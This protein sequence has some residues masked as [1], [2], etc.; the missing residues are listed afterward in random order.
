MVGLFT[1][2]NWLPFNAYDLSNIEKLK[3]VRRL[4]R[5]VFARGFAGQVNA[6]YFFLYLFCLCESVCV[7]G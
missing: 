1:D 2:C 6:D 4:R 5:P 7:R 3:G